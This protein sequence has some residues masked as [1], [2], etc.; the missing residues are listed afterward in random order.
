MMRFVMRG[1]RLSGVARILIITERTLSLHPNG[2]RPGIGI[3]GVHDVNLCVNARVSAPVA[4]RLTE[5]ILI[6]QADDVLIPEKH[7]TFMRSASIV[8]TSQI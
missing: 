2:I 1:Y 3:I 4:R 7:C 8:D 6:T 5:Q